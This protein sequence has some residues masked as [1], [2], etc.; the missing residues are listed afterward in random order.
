[1]KRQRRDAQSALKTLSRGTAE[2]ATT[3]DLENPVFKPF[4]TAKLT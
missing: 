2:G 3:S 4:S 1:M